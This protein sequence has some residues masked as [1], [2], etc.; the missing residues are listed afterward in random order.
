[1]EVEETEANGALGSTGP[2]RSQSRLSWPLIFLVNVCLTVIPGV[3][4]QWAPDQEM[5]EK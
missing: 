4:L 2:R 5:L 1:M 3:S